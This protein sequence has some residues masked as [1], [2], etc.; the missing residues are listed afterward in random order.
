[1]GYPM[2]RDAIECL[3]RQNAKEA[4]QF[5]LICSG[6]HHAKCAEKLLPYV[7]TAQDNGQVWLA[8]GYLRGICSN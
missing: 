1:M 5:G 2:T 8:I 3:H 6:S 7:Q 4:M